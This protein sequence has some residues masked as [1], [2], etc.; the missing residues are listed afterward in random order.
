MKRANISLLTVLTVAVWVGGALAAAAETV[1]Y[2][3]YSLNL[4]YTNLEARYWQV[5]GGPENLADTIYPQLNYRNGSVNTDS[6]GKISGV[7]RWTIAYSGSGTP[8]STLY[9]TVSGKLTGKIG[10]PATVTMTIKGEGYTVNGTG[11]ATPFKGNLKFTGQVGPNPANPGNANDLRMVGTLSG[12]FTGSTVVGAK[13]FKLPPNRLG[14]VPDS[15]YNSAGVGTTVVQSSGG[16]MQLV[17]TSLQG[18][19]SIKDKTTYRATVKGTG[20]NKGISV[21]LS[22]SVGLT[23]GNVGTNPIPFLAPITAEI[24]KGSKWNGQEIQGMASS[25]RVSLIV[26]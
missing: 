25:I 19:G 20:S 16:K 17:G 8:S 7:G 23:T 4:S 3:A 10:S 24:L 21:S 5:D 26:D 22:G 6:S 18:N 2:H 14:Y 11:F 15:D 13:G 9:G 1:T 12:S